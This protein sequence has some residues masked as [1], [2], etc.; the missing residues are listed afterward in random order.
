MS[1]AASVRTAGI[2]K[3]AKT[4]SSQRVR[5][6]LIDV[7]LFAVF[8]V[9]GFVAPFERNTVFWLSYGA[10]A[11]AL[12]VQLF[13]FPRAFDFE[14]HAVKSKIYGF[15]LARISTIYLVVQLVLSLLFMIL[16]KGINIKTWIVIILYVVVLAVA[17]IGLVAADAAK[18]EVQRQ[19]TVHRKNASTMRTLQATASGTAAACEDAALKK[20]LEKFAEDVRFSDPVSSEALTEIEGRLAGQ[21]G[22]L[23]NAVAEKDY[24]YAEKLLDKTS[25]TLAERNR[26]CRANKA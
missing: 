5:F 21:L 9:I 12:I 8:T 14:G 6:Y 10:G 15:P 20:K 13:V 26:L 1:G 11:L 2:R 25:A 17:A 4:M 16:C 3:K 18:E 7:I 24:S 23:K 19:E 22:E